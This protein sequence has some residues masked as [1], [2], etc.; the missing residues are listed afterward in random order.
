MKS[1]VRKLCLLI[2]VVLVLALAFAACGRNETQP[3][4]P[5]PGQQQEAP[6][7]EPAPEPEPE[8]E[9][10]DEPTPVPEPEPDPPTPPPPLP[11]GRESEAVFT[12]TPPAIDGVMDAVWN[13]APVMPI[14]RFVQ[15]DRV[16]GEGRL[17]W[18]Y[19]Y[20]YAWMIIFD[21]DLHAAGSQPWYNDSMD[22][23][24][25]ERRTTGSSYEQGD[26]QYR[27]NF[28]NELTGGAAT[29]EGVHTATRVSVGEYFVIEM[30]IP[31]RYVEPQE[32]HQ[33][34]WDMQINDG[35]AAGARVGIT[36]WND[37]TCNSWN[38]PST[39]GTVT[40]V[41]GPRIENAMFTPEA[42][43]IDAEMDS[44][45]NNATPFAIEL[46]VYRYVDLP[47]NQLLTGESR[48]LWNANYLFVWV[49]ITDGGI[50][51]RDHNDPWMRS[52]VEIYLDEFNMKQ[53][54]SM[55]NGVQYRVDFTN[56]RT[57]GVS[58]GGRFLSATRETDNG[59]ILELQMPFL[60]R[61]VYN[62][63]IIGFELQL[64]HADDTGSRV[65]ITK[66]SDPTDDSWQ[67]PSGWG[68]LMLIGR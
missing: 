62:N 28:L 21:D 6:T 5:P 7:P 48:V 11:A 9:P 2:I 27:V 60:H 33:I 26:R 4:E 64:I 68:E 41:Y 8:P 10:A 20:L 61:E 44:I 17:L 36:K 22:I 19:S 54:F 63:A 66:F 43:S 50:R 30:R 29:F 39:F 24:F 46:P 16:T 51:N 55:A 58:D 34:G 65:S 12:N 37:T 35:N 13:R 49:E 31:F 15:G 38:D 40:L 1:F 42:P 53:S 45:W 14:D 67:N 56:D 25:S 32:G 57:D 18:D 23:Y 3:E 47:S 59:W 52:S